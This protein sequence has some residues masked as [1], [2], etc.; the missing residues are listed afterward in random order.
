[1]SDRGREALGETVREIEGGMAEGEK[2]WE[3]Q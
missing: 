1:M 2:H 3:R